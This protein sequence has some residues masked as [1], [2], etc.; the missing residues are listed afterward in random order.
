MITERQL[1][2]NRENAQKGGVKSEAGK[3]V[4]RM[5]ASKHGGMTNSILEGESGLYEEAIQALS[6]AESSKIFVEKILVERAA[7]CVLQMRRVSFAESEFV[8][9][10][11]DPTV[12]RSLFDMSFDEVVEPGYEAVVSLEQVE[13]FLGLY[14]RYQVS[15]ENRFLKINKELEAVRSGQ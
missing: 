15:L 10:I 3:L 9:Q 11:D 2:A 4:S 6:D 1:L 5:N 7:M 13:R 12:T 14:V 8:R